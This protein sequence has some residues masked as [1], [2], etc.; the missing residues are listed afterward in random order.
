MSQEKTIDYFHKTHEIFIDYGKCIQGFVFCTE[1][2]RV[3]SAGKQRTSIQAAAIQSNE[4]L[5]HPNAN[6]LVPRA[7]WGCDS[8]VC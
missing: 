6:A 3:V 8:N 2:C 7:A 4:I 1:S 5:L